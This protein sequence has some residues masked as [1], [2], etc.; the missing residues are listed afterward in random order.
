MLSQYLMLARYSVG[1]LQL[2][3]DRLETRLLAQGIQER[4]GLQ[5]LQSGIT[6]ADRRG[7]PFKRLVPI[8]PLRIDRGVLI[9][10]GVAP[11]CPVLCEYGLCVGVSPKLVVHDCQA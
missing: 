3:L 4:V 2:P 6:Q 11:P 8:A 10:A 1:K 9:S 7:E 5:E